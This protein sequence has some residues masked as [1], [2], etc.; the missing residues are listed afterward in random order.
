[1]KCVCSC[2]KSLHS[3]W[4]GGERDNAHPSANSHT[5]EVAE[6]LVFVV[7]NGHASR[8]QRLS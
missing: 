2:W 6:L 5:E 3:S 1:M 8:G 7:Q 4:L